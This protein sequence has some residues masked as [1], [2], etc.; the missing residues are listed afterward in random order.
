MSIVA[1][2]PLVLVYGCDCLLVIMFYVLMSQAYYILFELICKQNKWATTWQNQQ[3]DVRPVKY[4]IS[5]GIRPVWSESVQCTQWVAEDPMFL[6]ADSEDSDQT[7]WM[8]M[9][10]WVFAGHQGYFAGFVMRWFKCWND[11]YQIAR[12]GNGQLVHCRCT[13]ENQF[14]L[15][16]CI[17]KRHFMPETFISI[18]NNLQRS[19]RLNN[20]DRLGHDTVF[21]NLHFYMPNVISEERLGFSCDTSVCIIHIHCHSIWHSPIYSQNW[22]KNIN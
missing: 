7:G 22:N 18:D 10:I 1:H 12:L 14:D 3:N 5:L 20:I 21:W 11:Q 16:W 2:G 19:V 9:L 17:L 8:P 6:Y 15:S 13:I 4:Q